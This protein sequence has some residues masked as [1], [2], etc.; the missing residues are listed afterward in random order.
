M[1]SKKK[2]EL[3]IK[4]IE[5]YKIEPK[6]QYLIY[7]RDILIF[8]FNLIL[9][10]IKPKL[11]EDIRDEIANESVYKFYLIL[12]KIDTSYKIINLIY[13]IVK[14]TFINCMRT[15]NRYG[16]SFIDL[17]FPIDDIN[18]DELISELVDEVFNNEND[19]QLG[20]DFIYNKYSQKELAKKYN[21][22][23]M[24]MRKR[25]KPLFKIT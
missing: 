3:L 5:L 13:T 21:I 22:T 16:N 8:E 10:K 15:E 11:Q 1:E 19:K 6:Q 2:C 18:Y 17:D 9:R 14:N 25:L 23:Q 4:Y 12:N 24:T 7:I 20:Y